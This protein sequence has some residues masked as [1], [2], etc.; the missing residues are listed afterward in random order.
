MSHENVETVRAAFRAFDRGD[1]DAV[2][3]LCAEDIDIVQPAELPGVR[4]REPGH[5]GVL[6]AFAVWPEQWDDYRI[7]VLSAADVGDQVM[8][9]TRQSGR[10][11]DSGVPVQMDFTF[12][13]GFRAGKIAEWRIF[14]HEADALAAVRERREV[15]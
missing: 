14:M 15:R 3:D 11:K 1:I 8:V 7:E 12:L 5:A 9:R 2:L 13:F 10:G 6:Q 4:R